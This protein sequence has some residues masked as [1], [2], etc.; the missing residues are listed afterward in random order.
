MSIG[1]KAR[2][3]EQVNKITAQYD[4][5]LR[6][7]SGIDEQEE[8]V[9]TA[10]QVEII[11][12][13]MVRIYGGMGGIR[14]NNLFLSVCDAPYQEV[15][16]QVLYPT[17]YDK[18]AKILESFARYQIFY[19]GNKR[20]ALESAV[21]YLAMNNVKLELSNEEAYELTMDIALGKYQDT[22]SISSYLKEHSYVTRDVAAEY[23]KGRNIE[24]E[25]ER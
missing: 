4:N 22:F 11:H 6:R 18:A 21:V 23:E 3:E 19:D 1:K 13:E 14:D 12:D 24:N 8:F 7:L 16:G 10:V 17:V 20:T 9:L 25:L 5:A 15:F 2:F